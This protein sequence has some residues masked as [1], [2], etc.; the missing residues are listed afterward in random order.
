MGAMEG[1]SYECL[2]EPKHVAKTP[3][4]HGRTDHLPGEGRTGGEI[5][6]PGSAGKLS[7]SATVAGHDVGNAK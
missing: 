5:I 7:D 2:G 4:A 1:S 6:Q 3:P